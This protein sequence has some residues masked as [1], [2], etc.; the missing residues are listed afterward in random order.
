MRRRVD[1]RRRAPR[2]RIALRVCFEGGG[3]GTSRDI[4]AG[5]LFVDTDRR[6]QPSEPVRV[7]LALGEWDAAGGFRIHGEGHVV[8]ADTAGARPGV[9]LAVVWSDI[10]PL[11]PQPPATVPTDIV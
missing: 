3:S 10:E 2:L 5:G 9:G 8:R 6:L 4:S 1:E 7:S 11:D